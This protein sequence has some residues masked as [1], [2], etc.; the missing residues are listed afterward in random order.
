MNI[1]PCE[2]DD[3]SI[4]ALWFLRLEAQFRQAKITIDNFKFDYTVASLNSEVLIEV[5]D[6]VKNPTAG[7]AYIQLKARLLDRY[8][9]S[10]DE[11]IHKLME[12]TL[13]G[14]KPTQL[15]HRMQALAMDSI[16][17]Q[18]LKNFWL[19]RLPSS[20]RSV[21]SILDGDL[22]ELAKKADTYFR[23]SSFPWLLPKGRGC[24]E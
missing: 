21:I 5:A 16:S 4:M 1:T 19:D 8:G 7:N 20:V 2:G 22:E 17:T 6:I 15:L 14:L 23:C 18:V 11:K 10:S 24:I 12:L 9:T 3:H 13:G